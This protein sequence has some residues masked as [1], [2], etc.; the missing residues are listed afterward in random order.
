[1][2]TMITEKEPKTPKPVEMELALETSRVL[3]P[4]LAEGTDLRLQI[5]GATSSDLVVPNRAAKMLL[6]ILVQIGRGNAVQLSSLEPEISTQE[7]AELLN[8]SRPYVVKLA[9]EGAIPSRKVGPRRLLKLD[10][11]IAYKREMYVKRLEAIGE[12]TR[13]SEEMGLYDTDAKA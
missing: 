12:M 13:L 10:D 1:M 11:V 3:A 9:D 7:A 8:V 5:R 6:D 2:S 4:L